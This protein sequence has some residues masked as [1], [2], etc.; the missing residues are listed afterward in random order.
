M[1]DARRT[2]VNLVGSTPPIDLELVEWPRDRSDPSADDLDET[3]LVIPSAGR[4]VADF[5]DLA[6][7]LT[8]SGRRVV[9][10]EPRG[11]GRS[12]GLVEDLRLEQLAD[13]HAAALLALGVERAVVIGHAFGN[14]VARMLAARHPE[15]ISGVV[16]LACGGM[17]PMPAEMWPSFDIVFDESRSARDR[18]DAVRHCFFADGNDASVWA[19]GWFSEVIDA[20]NHASEASP[21][22]SWASAGTEAPVLVVQPGQDRLAPERNAELLVELL[23]DRAER[24]TVDGAGHALLPERPDELARVVLGWLD[25][26]RLG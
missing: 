8:S 21:L 18:L 11:I 17:I 3:V 5:D 13:D 23:G 2:I 25:R 10:M 16:L 9:A 24:V 4:A 22:E 7:R 6:R 20:Q 14:R 15:V 1:N 12:T 26:R 19:D